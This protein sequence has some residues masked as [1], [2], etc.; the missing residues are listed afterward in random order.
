MEMFRRNNDHAGERMLDAFQFSLTSLLLISQSI[1]DPHPEE[2]QRGGSWTR[3]YTRVVG[4][5]RR[6]L[7]GSR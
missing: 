1:V 2:D 5:K 6:M 3:E 7:D 4:V